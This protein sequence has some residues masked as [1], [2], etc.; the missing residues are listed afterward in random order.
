ME[1]TRVPHIGYRKFLILLKYFSIVSIVTRIGGLNRVTLDDGIKLI[2]V[3][4][5]Q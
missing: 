2:I 5:D 4:I 1:E 3:D